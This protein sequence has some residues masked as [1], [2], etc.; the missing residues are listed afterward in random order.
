MVLVNVV[1]EASLR[2]NTL[3][4]GGA[5]IRVFVGMIIGAMSAIMAAGGPAIA[6]QIMGNAA[7][8]MHR[9]TGFPDYM[10]LVLCG[11]GIIAVSGSVRKR[12]QRSMKASKYSFLLR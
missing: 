5:M 6:D 9:S 2:F 11:W 10:L 1:M 8:L 3:T 7:T 12:R 4:D